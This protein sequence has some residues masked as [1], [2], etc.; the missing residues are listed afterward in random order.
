MPASF[1]LDDSA[2]IPPADPDEAAA[3]E[4]LRGPNIKPFPEGKPVGTAFP[5]ASPSRW[6]II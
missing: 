3:L 5:P 1:K 2:V 6:G 4:V